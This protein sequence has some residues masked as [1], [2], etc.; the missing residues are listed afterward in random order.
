MCTT[1]QEKCK[2][3]GE[4]AL[5][6]WL[7]LV[8]Y[9]IWFLALAKDYIP[10]TGRETTFLWKLHKRQTHCCSSKFETVRHGKKVVGFRC[11][12]GHEYLSK[13]LI[14]QHD[15]RERALA[16]LGKNECTH[17]EEA[18]YLERYE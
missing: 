1:R 2:M 12:C 13:R 11:A 7:F 6:M 17:Q 5:A 14:T 10:L 9:I 8:A 4:L 15:L 16:V 3:I 18:V